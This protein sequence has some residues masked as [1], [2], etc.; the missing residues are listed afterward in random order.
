MWTASRVPIYLKNAQSGVSCSDEARRH[1][2][3]VCSDGKQMNDL[4]YQVTLN[5][6]C[7]LRIE[8][9]KLSKH[10]RNL[11]QYRISRKYRMFLM[12]QEDGWY[13][14]RVDSIMQSLLDVDVCRSRPVEPQ[15]QK[16]VNLCC[17]LRVGIVSVLCMLLHDRITYE[18]PTLYRNDIR[19]YIVIVLANSLCLEYRNIS[20]VCII[21]ERAK[22]AFGSAQA[23]RRYLLK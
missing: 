9:K 6:H 17:Q 21:I 1:S 3:Y 2:T 5:I 11:E 18:V 20:Q 15:E 8:S 4:V 10:Y 19:L 13:L 23:N 16:V 22:R 14:N 7:T 12:N